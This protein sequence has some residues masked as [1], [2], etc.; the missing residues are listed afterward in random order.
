MIK[1]RTAELS[2]L[3]KIV[4]THSLSA[5]K[6]YSGLLSQDTLSATFNPNI[7]KGNWKTSFALKER[8]PLSRCLLVAEDDE[9]PELGILGVAR[10][11]VIKNLTERSFFDSVMGENGVQGNLSEIQT[12]YIHPEYQKHGIGKALMREMAKFL[13]K[14]NCKK[15]IVITLDGYHTS[16]HFYQK[17]A[18]A[19]YVGQFVQNTAETAGAANPQSG[20]S[21]F[22][23]W[24]FNDISTCYTKPMNVQYLK[25][26]K[27]LNR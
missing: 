21:T 15:S 3:D 27:G 5:I 19:K 8:D 14:N 26:K 1:V 23:L 9:R 11:H 6:A 13:V 12:L 17:T 2:E 16:A 7:L 24:L 4:Q 20:S 25:M 18:G 22:N 10:C